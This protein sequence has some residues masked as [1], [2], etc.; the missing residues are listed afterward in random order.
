MTQP[1]DNQQR[2]IALS[3]VAIPAIDKMVPVAF[4]KGWKTKFRLQVALHLFQLQEFQLAW[5][6]DSP[7]QYE[8]SILDAAETALEFFD[9][10][11]CTLTAAF[12]G[13]QQ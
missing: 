10:D 6:N 13:E 7:A 4:Y 9:T 8:D 11:T 3:K 1:T 2:A 5:D 12:H